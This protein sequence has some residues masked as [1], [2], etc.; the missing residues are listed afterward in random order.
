VPES[1]EDL[2]ALPPELFAEHVHSF[3]FWFGAVQGYLEGASYG[4]H[5][6]MHIDTGGDARDRQHLGPNGRARADCGG[7]GAGRPGLGEALAS[8]SYS[9]GVDR[10]AGGGR[11]LRRSPGAV[12]AAL[13]VCRAQGM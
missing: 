12:S 3:E 13:G 7:D 10:S 9:R 8:A 1:M 4:R 2:H 11:V 5:A 6:G